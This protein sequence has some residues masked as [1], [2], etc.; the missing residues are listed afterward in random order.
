MLGHNTFS[1]LL[2][3][4]YGRGIL[5]F[6]NRGPV[7]HMIQTKQTLWN[8][9]V[10]HSTCFVI[11]SVKVTSTERQ[12]WLLWNLPRSELFQGNVS[13]SWR[14]EFVVY[15]EEQPERIHSVVT[16][17]FNWFWQHSWGNNCNVPQKPNPGERR[18]SSCVDAKKKKKKKIHWSVEEERLAECGWEHKDTLQTDE[19]NLNVMENGPN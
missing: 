18:R 3:H 19:R 2:Y 11:S 5:V 10:N 6:L 14:E 9:S 12:K 1:F 7:V 4:Q 8:R 13:K 15:L 16:W 17:L